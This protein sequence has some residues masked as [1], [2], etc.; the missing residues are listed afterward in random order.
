[1]SRDPWAAWRPATCM[2]DACFCEQIHPGY[3]RQPVNAVSG[4]AFLA[5]ALLV[6]RSPRRAGNP[7]GERPVFGAIYAL[8]LVAVG[9]GTVFYHASLTFW[10]QT[11]DVLGMYLLGTFLLLYNAARLRPMSARCAATAYLLTNAVLLSGLVVAPQLRRYLF[12]LLI[13]ATLALELV[14]RRRRRVQAAAGYLLAAL[15][16]LALGFTV[17]TLDLLRLVCSQGS[18]LQGHAVWHLCGALA[19]WM[20]HRYYRSEVSERP[21]LAPRP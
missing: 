13:L 19:A 20:I 18:I 12:A 11:A 10:G 7:L 5:V 1:M 6:V 16:T 21:G 17:W 2:P 4:L 14:L 3:L 15:G 8:A 9:L